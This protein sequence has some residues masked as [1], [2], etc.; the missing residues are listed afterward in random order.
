[1]DEAYQLAL[2]AEEKLNR[3]IKAAIKRG[4][5]NMNKGRGSSSKRTSEA[6]FSSELKPDSQ[7]RETPW[8]RGRGRAF[9]R[10]DALEVFY[11][12]QPP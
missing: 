5:S 6:E 8:N 10:L 1:M 7:G 3:R 9:A 11:M 4:G 12:Q 2:K